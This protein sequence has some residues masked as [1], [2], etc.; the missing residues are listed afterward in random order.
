MTYPY[1][2]AKAISYGGS[3]N[4]SAVKYIVIH[5]TG[6]NGDTAKGNCNY[7]A[8]GNTRHAGAHFFVSQNGEVYQSIKMSQSAYSVGGKKYNNAGG[9]YYGQCINSNSVSIEMCDNLNKDPSPAQTEAVRKLVAYIKQNCPNANTIIRHYD[10][11]GKPCPARMVD[12]SKWAAFKTSITTGTPAAATPKPAEKKA[13]VEDLTKEETTKLIDTAMKKALGGDGSSVS[14]WAVD[15]YAEAK[16]LGI[17]DGT[18]P[19]GRATREEVAVMLC[20]LYKLLAEKKE[21]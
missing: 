7:F 2:P 18:R 17:T 1:I 8:N 11:N 5:Y 16:R 14:T 21:A 4:L 10:V 19:Q 13:E 12:G 9:K 20:R 6:N 15:E 3:R